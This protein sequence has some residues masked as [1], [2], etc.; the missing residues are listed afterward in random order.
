MNNTEINSFELLKELKTE[1]VEL[2]KLFLNPNNPR[3]MG[4]KR[5]D[6]IE[7]NRINEDKIQEAVKKEIVIEGISDLVEKIKRHGFLTID[8]IVV[9]PIKESTDEYVVLE[10]NRRVTTLKKLYEDHSHGIKT[11][12]QDLLTSITVFEVLVYSGNDDEIEWILQGMRHINGIKEWGPLQQSRFLAEMQKKKNLTPTQL[13]ELTSLGRNTISN[14]IR[15]YNAWEYTRENYH[16]D[17]KE[18]HYSLFQEAVFAR[19][20]IREWLGWNDS[21]NSFDNTDNFTLLCDWY[22]GDQNGNKKLQRALEVRDLLSKILIKE[23]KSILDKFINLDEYTYQEAKLELDKKNAEK[24]AEKESLN[25]AQR[26]EEIASSITNIKT[27]PSSDIVE[28]KELKEKFI[29]ELKSLVKASEFQIRIL[30]S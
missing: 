28:E 16:G 10:G 14:K 7:D 8:R 9:R 26:L 30:N 1:T 12:D 2:S 23:N 19:P 5:N 29:K 24:E 3:I 17:I 15:S 11:L 20:N 18:E 22:L 21:S 6:K 13:D 4:K 27:L 25:L